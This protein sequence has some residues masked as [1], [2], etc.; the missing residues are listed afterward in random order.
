VGTPT[1]ATVRSPAVSQ[2]DVRMCFFLCEV[3]C[4]G[5]NLGDA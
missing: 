1:R 2:F 5:Q 3:M 4:V